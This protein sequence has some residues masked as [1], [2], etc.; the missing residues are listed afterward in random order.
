MCSAKSSAAIRIFFPAVIWGPSR[1]S[2]RAM[3]TSAVSSW[4]CV[5]RLPPPGWSPRSPSRRA[6]SRRQP[7]ANRASSIWM[8]RSSRQT[9]APSLA[10][11]AT[12]PRK[13]SAFRRAGSIAISSRRRACCGCAVSRARRS[14][15]RASRCARTI[16]AGATGSSTSTPM[17]AR[18]TAPH[19][20][21]APPRWSPATSGYQPCCSRSR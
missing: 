15:W 7:K 13:V 2:I 20:R 19:S 1:G 16:S 8:S 9:C 3:A 14:S 11:S 4:T 10:R 18:S 6:K 17:P 5:A 12:E 21:R